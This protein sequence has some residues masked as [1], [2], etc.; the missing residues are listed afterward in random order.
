MTPGTYERR[1][2][3]RTTL[4]LEPDVA[5]HVGQEV[6]RTGRRMK[7]IVNQA[8]RLGLGIAKVPTQPPRFE[9]QSHTFRFNPDIDLNRM[10]QLLDDLE[11]EEVARKLGAAHP[12]R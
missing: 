10:H 4:T 2:L 8:L 9:V 12:L 6:E 1:M 11:A 7:E 5:E 3:M